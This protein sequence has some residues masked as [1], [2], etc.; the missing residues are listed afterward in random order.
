MVL[1]IL[2]IASVAVFGAIIGSFLNVVIFRLP[3]GLSVHKPTWSFC[4]HCNKRIRPYHNLPIVGWLW[5]RGRCHDCQSSISIVYPLIECTTVFLFVMVWDAMFV[6]RVLPGIHHPSHDWPMAIAYLSLFAGLLATSAMDIESYIID[7]RLSVLSMILG[8]IC[9]TIWGIPSGS[10]TAGGGTAASPIGH[11]TLG[12]LPASLCV[13]GVAMGLVWMLT[14]LIGSV[15]AKSAPNNGASGLPDDNISEEELEPGQTAYLEAGGRNFRPTAIILFGTAILGLI[16][17]QFIVPNQSPGWPIAAGDLRGVVAGLILMVLLVLV[18]LVPRESDE[19]IV[20]E[21]ESER[22]QARST[23]LREFA[24]FVPAILVGSGLFAYFRVSGQLN[25]GLTEIL[26]IPASG[27][28]EHMQSGCQAVAAAVFAAA[29]GWTVR[30]LGTLT[31]GKEAFG[32]GDIYIMAAIAAVLGFW[33]VF[34]TFFL[35]TILALIGVLATLVRKTSRAIPF[36]P[37]LALGAF[38]NLWLL[39]PLLNYYQTTGQ[40]LWSILSR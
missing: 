23:A 14:V 17:W 10:A 26:S 28:I 13:I 34:F 20:D 1:G 16:V 30:I 40:L 3:R 5:L 7:I 6:A 8:I 12:L 21:I 31:F 9:Y 4:P 15:L 35:A 36:G 32:T 19:Q 24:W 29:L 25:T 37:W 27:W 33:S 39:G 2:Q 11:D 18:S 38:V 22:E